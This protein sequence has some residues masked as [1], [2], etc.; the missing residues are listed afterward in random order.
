MTMF[1]IMSLTLVAVT[2]VFALPSLVQAKN[3]YCA[4][5]NGIFQCF[6]RESDCK[7][8]AEANPETKCLR[9]KT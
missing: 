1:V 4:A 5:G 2:V 8:F 7:S 9:T 3:S 6:I